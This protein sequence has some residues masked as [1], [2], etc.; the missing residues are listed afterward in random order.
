[1]P[2]RTLDDIL[3]AVDEFMSYHR[4][5]E[6][7]EV[8]QQEQGDDARIGFMTRFESIATQVKLADGGI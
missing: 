1:M 6:D 7:Q 2:G 4:Q 8:Q 3:V 5:V